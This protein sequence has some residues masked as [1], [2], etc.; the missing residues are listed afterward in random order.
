MQVKMT[1]IAIQCRVHSKLIGWGKSAQI[2]QLVHKACWEHQHLHDHCILQPETIKFSHEVHRVAL[3]YLKILL[4]VLPF[5]SYY[6]GKIVRAFNP[7]T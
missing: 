5:K 4:C 2:A 1:Y 3:D 6:K 7:S